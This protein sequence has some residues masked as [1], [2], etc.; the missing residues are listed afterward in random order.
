ML[1]V[2]YE[3]ETRVSA[4]VMA[5]TLRL[6]AG[7]ALLACG[8]SAVPTAKVAFGRHGLAEGEAD[9]MYAKE[10]TKVVSLSP[11][12]VSSA[13]AR[14][15]SLDSRPELG[16]DL[17]AGDIFNRPDANVMVFV[18]GVRPQGE[19]FRWETCTAYHD[20]QLRV[21]SCRVCALLP[22]STRALFWGLGSSARNLAGLLVENLSD[23]D[24]QKD[25]DGVA[26]Y[27]SESVQSL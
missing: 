1:S 21:E 23:P 19:R 3:W 5:L 16:T 7:L 10:N 2:I 4:R 8:A 27:S 6:G 20:G 18:D 17:P 15:M 25:C 9:V 12:M 22:C 14:M 24:P 26:L 11:Q 13:I